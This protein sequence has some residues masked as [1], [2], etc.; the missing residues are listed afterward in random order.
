MNITIEKHNGT[1]SIMR[2]GIG[3]EVVPNSILYG[4]SAPKSGHQKELMHRHSLLWCR[5]MKHML[6]STGRGVAK[7]N[8]AVAGFEILKG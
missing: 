4:A 6:V 2:E 3:E 1:R 7:P 8:H 5:R